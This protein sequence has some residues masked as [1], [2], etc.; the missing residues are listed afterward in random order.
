MHSQA[1]TCTHTVHMYIYTRVHTHRR[2]VIARMTKNVLKESLVQASEQLCVCVLCGSSADEF[3][4]MHY[5]WLPGYRLGC[6]LKMLR[7]LIS[8]TCMCLWCVTVLTK[9]CL[10]V[11]AGE[12]IKN[13]RPRFFV[14][15]SDGTFT[16][17][18]QGP[19][20]GIY[21]EPLNYFKVEGVCVCVF[22]SV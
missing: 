9:C 11:L 20:G 7:F 15:R 5:L 22:M 1:Y 16:G 17:Y 19:I 14:V 12:F 4:L 3:A 6:V 2:H 8:D 21:P 18:K 13:W 10:L